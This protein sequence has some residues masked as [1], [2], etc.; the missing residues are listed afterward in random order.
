MPL[1]LFVCIRLFEFYVPPTAL[2]ISPL[3]KRKK[4]KKKRDVRSICTSTY[5]SGG[6]S[7]RRG[8][9]LS[10]GQLLLRNRCSVHD[11]LRTRSFHHAFVGSILAMASSRSGS[12]SIRSGARSSRSI[13]LFVH[14]AH[15]STTT[16]FIAATLSRTEYTLLSSIEFPRR[17]VNGFANFGSKFD[18]RSRHFSHIFARC[19]SL[20]HC[21][22][23]PF[24]LGEKYEIYIYLFPCSLTNLNNLR[25][26]QL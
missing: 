17:T 6:M 4:K 13:P 26:E 19:W 2:S 18:L 10:L 7:R 11:T 25:G 9:H 24:L 15:N 1:Y 8:V 16:R 3:R 5:G 14:R 21:G 22:A 12:G 23:T 20:V